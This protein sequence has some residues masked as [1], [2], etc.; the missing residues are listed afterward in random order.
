MKA[1]NIRQKE[2][3]K[4]VRPWLEAQLTAKRIVTLSDAP[5][6]IKHVPLRAIEA[7]VANYNRKNNV[8]FGIDTGNGRDPRTMA[9]VQA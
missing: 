8:E 2:A 4:T 7:T 9:L 3:L 1:L 6:A 5:E